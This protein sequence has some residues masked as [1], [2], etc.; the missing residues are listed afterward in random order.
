MWNATIACPCA[1]RGCWTAP[2]T[3]AVVPAVQPVAPLW[4]RATTTRLYPTTSSKGPPLA[5][6]S[7]CMRYSS[8]GM[9]Y[10]AMPG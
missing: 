10:S 3:S 2:L 1:S 5:Y 6:R 9:R 4:V 7:T 8:T